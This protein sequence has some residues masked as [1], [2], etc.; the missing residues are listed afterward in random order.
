[1][2]LSGAGLTLSL[3]DAWNVLDALAERA[4]VEL[5]EAAPRMAELSAELSASV[6][7]LY[8]RERQA[9]ALLEGAQSVDA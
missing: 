4:A 1:M 3:R 6:H 8:T 5:K 9:L 2:A 7:A